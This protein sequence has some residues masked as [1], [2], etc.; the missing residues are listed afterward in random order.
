MATQYQVNTILTNGAVINSGVVTLPTAN[1]ATSTE[2]G[3]VMPVAKTDG[4]TQEV[5][6]DST[7]KLYTAPGGGGTSTPTHLY[8]NL[9][10]AYKDSDYFMF[11]FPATRNFDSASLPVVVSNISLSQN[12]G[13]FP[14]SGVIDGKVVTSLKLNDV[15]DELELKFSDGTT[16]TITSATSGWYCNNASIQ[17]W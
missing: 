14:A 11:S 15:R 3:L 1:I 13:Y 5:G 2:A 10:R 8:F 4:M 17:L 9:I 7:G 6:V 12:V 16:L